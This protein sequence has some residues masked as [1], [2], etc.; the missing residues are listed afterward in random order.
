GG[1]S[2]RARRRAAASARRPSVRP[3][4]TAAT[5]QGALHPK[6]RAARGS[7]RVGPPNRRPKSDVAGGQL[8]LGPLSLVLGPWSGAQGPLYPG[9]RCR[10]GAEDQGPGPRTRS[11]IGLVV[12]DRFLTS[13]ETRSHRRAPDRRVTCEEQ[14]ARPTA[15]ERPRG[16][17]FMCRRFGG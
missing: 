8:S 10:P 5:R 7:C 17:L 11:I 6:R 1:A 12:F 14:R 9:D 16:V 15:P 13:Y 3:D 2:D 4:A